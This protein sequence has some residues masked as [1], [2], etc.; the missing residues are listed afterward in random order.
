MALV[1]ARSA[2]G[3]LLPSAPDSPTSGVLRFQSSVRTSTGAVAPCTV[4][5]DSGSSVNMATSK[6]LTD[7][8]PLSEA[9]T[10]SAL[11]ESCSASA[12]GTARLVLDAE[13][14][15]KAQPFPVECIVMDTIG[16][17]S[18]GIDVLLNAETGAQLGYL[19]SAPSD[20]SVPRNQ[21]PILQMSS[22][23]NKRASPR[24]GR[25]RRR[26]RRRPERPAI[27]QLCALAEARV[28]SV[29]KKKTFPRAGETCYSKQDIKWG[30][31]GRDHTP[32]Q[33][34]AFEAL[35]D[36]YHDIFLKEA[37]PPACACAPVNIPL[38]D[39]GARIP[40][41]RHGQWR[42][43][44][45][46]YLKK[47][48]EQ[49]ESFDVIEKCEQPAG[50]SRVTL[51]AKGEFDIRTCIDLR[52]VNKL[53]KDFKHFYTN[54]PDQVS[55][56]CNSGHRFRSSFDLASAYSQLAVDEESRRLLGV[57]LPDENGRPTVY[58]YKRLPFGL[59][60]SG[61]YLSRFLESAFAELPHD[62]LQ[63]SFFYYMDDIVITSPSFEAHERHVRAFF[64]V[65]RK[66]RLKVSYKKAQAL[67]KEVTFY[68]YVCSDSGTSLT[69]ENTAALRAM[70]YP[71]N[72]SECRHVIGV[73]SVAR[74][75]VP[76]FAH[77]M[78]P[79]LRLVRQGTPWNFGQAEQA[80]FDHVR[81][82]LVR[83][84]K[85]H[86]FDPNLPLVLHTDASGVAE[87]AWLA[88]QRPSGELESIAFYSKGFSERMRRQGATSREAHA[89]IFGLHAA[90]VYCHSSIHP[91]TVF[92]DCR[93]L[94]F[95]KDSSKSELSVRFL[96]QL[97]DH[98]FVIKYKRGS[99]N[100][101]ADAFSR[102]PMHGPNEPTRAGTAT[103]L[104]DLLQHLTGT[105]VHSAKNVWVHVAEYSE[106]AYRTVQLW[107]GQ[108]QLR[109]KMCNAAPT[110]EVMSQQHD[111][112][113]LRFDPHEA[114]ELAR[115]ALRQDCPTAILFPLDLTGQVSVDE[116]GNTIRSV[117]KS[118]QRAKL[119]AYVGS[120]NV[121]ILHRIR[122]AENDVCLA[123]DTAPA[124]ARDPVPADT[125]DAPPP[126]APL[127]AIA[128]T[129]VPEDPLPDGTFSEHA[130]YGETRHL[131]ERLAS[132]LDVAT[133]PEL[134]TVDDI[135][136]HLRAK[137]VSDSRGLKWLQ[138]DEGAD[139][140]IV[141]PT[142]RSLLLHLVHVESNHAKASSLARE[143]LRSYYWPN[144]RTDAAD[145]VRQC[146][147]CALG[148]VR[149]VLHHNLYASSSYTT[150]REVI[151][152]DFK[153]ISVG[154]EVSYLLLMVDKFSGFAT[155]AVLPDRT[156]ASVIQGL[157][158]EFYSIFG[159]AARVTIDGAKEFRS[160]KLRDWLSAMGSK[161]VTPMEFY[162]QSQGYVE[163]V[164]GM[165][166][167]A[168]RRTTDFSAWKAEL[169]QAIY[170]YNALRKEDCPSPYTLF[171]GGQ[172]PS[173]S[174]LIAAAAREFNDPNLRQARD[175]QIALADGTSAI[176]SQAAADKNLKRRSRTVDLNRNGRSPPS[177]KVGDKVWF[178]QDIS[179]GVT[180]TR[181]GDRP[182]SALT[183]WMP[184]TITRIEGP[185]HTIAPARSGRRRPGQRASF[186]RHRS[187]LKHRVGSIA[188]EKAPAGAAD[189]VSAGGGVKD[190]SRVS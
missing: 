142:Y 81:D 157:D 106:D 28:A 93:S 29:L 168:M 184:G 123:T 146:N 69:D 49:L 51:A 188:P 63:N 13:G 165:V 15:G 115:E 171:F 22:I 75:F 90:R 170:Q 185:R 70:P 175:V 36:E 1:A 57:T 104:D 47:V 148:N 40:F 56:V 78:E 48:R 103:A 26:P 177:F 46:E 12:R 149:R 44:E 41:E 118:V 18:L 143:L 119:R 52:R 37:L 176:R 107:R 167:T 179:G 23:E 58:T 105:S 74:R 140:L 7:I 64:D 39:P 114:V 139:Q 127:P 124:A 183:P 99:D 72:V 33:R 59:A 94:T 62:M 102:I 25:R 138:V 111:L 24:G 21:L 73:L 152:L 141:P 4:L 187:H 182:R 6:Y 27:Q 45:R 17:E 163:R 68:G 129:D 158:E 16:P 155:V 10:V 8:R 61:A 132:D 153:K 9:L 160:K 89:V 116:H 53:L 156:A 190:G 2:P 84:V 96:Q 172:P 60:S 113:I 34:Q 71:T 65:C 134:Q 76:R 79:L 91:T 42:P 173:S 88:Q 117:L 136:A 100:I 145:F 162:P 126:G 110:P 19:T 166:R 66:R 181:G 14:G 178:W 20:L 112:R 11:S 131:I 83:G 122:G 5:I 189:G 32:E 43:Q 82:A 101:V 54:G 144:L 180:N 120:N 108:Q 137:V 31:A 174:S 92:T 77:H 55:R 135:P 109:N 98:R 159:P 161:L 97:Q 128:V 3:L 85:L 125:S 87:A 154:T 80:A 67:C 35:I 130:H 95:V 86:A 151:G 30:K 164:W 169:R 147:K 150:P 50:S 38:K 133:W 121:W 186:E